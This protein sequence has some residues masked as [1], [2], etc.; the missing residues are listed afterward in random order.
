MLKIR[1]ILS[2]VGALI[3]IAMGVYVNIY[4]GLSGAWMFYGVGIALVIIYLLRRKMRLKFIKE[5]EKNS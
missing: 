5:Q 4:E 2:L 3:V 1:E